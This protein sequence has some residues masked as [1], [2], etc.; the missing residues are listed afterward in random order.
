L[1]A[2]KGL[3]KTAPG[4]RR[5]ACG[6]EG[7]VQKAHL[8]ILVVDDYTTM[9]RILRSLL[10]Q[11]GF[12]DVD[13]A[14]SGPEALTKL[15]EKEYSLVISDWNMAPMTGLELLREMR[16]DADL[17]DIPFIMVTAESKSER[18]L[19]AK[20]AGVDN[21]IVKPFNAATLKAKIAALG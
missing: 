7:M 21:Y 15:Q 14:V 4:D 2:R 8:P 18:V 11:V 5:L 13:E 3:G 6:A 1:N 16:A 10:K 19:E 12:S 9:L 20:Q 17:K